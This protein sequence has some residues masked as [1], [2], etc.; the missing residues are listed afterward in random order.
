M[1][2]IFDILEG[3]AQ[4]CPKIEPKNIEP[5]P[6]C[7]RCRW[8][9]RELNENGICA[10]CQSTLDRGYEISMKTGRCRTG[11]DFTNSYKFHARPLNNEGWPEHKALCGTEPGYRSRWSEWEPEDREVDCPRCLKKLESQV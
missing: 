2:S 11:S 4:D 9:G 5:A 1:P 8:T 6:Q 10:D 3:I 7:K